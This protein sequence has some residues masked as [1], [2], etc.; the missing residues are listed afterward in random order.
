[1][2]QQVYQNLNVSY[3]ILLS[4]LAIHIHKQSNDVSKSEFFSS[5]QIWP[6]LK[7]FCGGWNWVQWKGTLCGRLSVRILNK[8]ARKLGSYLKNLETLPTHPPTGV[9]ARICYRI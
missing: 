5:S 7:Q 4:D 1:M 3:L 8:Q 9:G 2:F 6:L